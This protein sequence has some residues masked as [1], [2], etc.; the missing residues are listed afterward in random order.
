MPFDRF[1]IAPVNTGLQTNLRPWLIQDDA[2]QSLQNAYIFRGRVRKRFG[3]TL[4]DINPL[5]SR[6]RINIGTVAAHTIPGVATQLKI[7]QMFSV[8]NDIFTIFQLGAG[9]LTKSTNAGVT[10]TI[11]STTNPNTVVFTGEPGASIVYYYPAEPVMGLTQYETGAVNNHPSY[12]FDEQFAY[13]FTPGSGWNRSGTAVWHGNDLNFFWTTNWKGITQ[14]VVAM[15]VTNFHV[16]NLNG[17]GV[18]TDDPIWETQN[19]STWA[20]FTPYFLPNSG[21]MQTGPF[22]QTCRIIVAFKDRLVLLNTVENDN[23]GGTGVNSWYPQRARFSF[24]GSP[25]ARNAW[26]EPGQM[27]ASGGVVNNNNI[28]AG[29]GFVDA[30]TDEQIIS[31]EFIKDRLIVYFERSTW[32]L[33]YTG[34]EILPFVWQK[35]NTELGS[36]STFSTIPFDREV[37]TI[38]NT[39]VHSCNGSNVDRIDIKIPDE[40]FEFE[41]KNNG[42]LRTAGIR[43]YFSELSYWA[44]VSDLEEPTQKFPNQM[45]IYNY[46]NQSWALND[47]CFTAFGYFEQ[48]S[49]STWQ[50]LEDTTWEQANFTWNSGIEEANQRVVIAGTPDGFVLIIN[51]EI[52]R[53]AASMYIT[54]MTIPSAINGVEFVDLEVINHNFAVQD[55]V[56]VENTVGISLPILSIYPVVK[57]IDANNITIKAPDIS[58]TYLGG[59]TL[60][61]VSN[62]Q[63]L[64]KQYNPYVDK[65]RNVYLHKVDFAVL[66]TEDGQITVDYFPSD[67]NLSMIDQGEGTG[68]IMG[69]N[70][71]ETS[72][73]DPVLYPLEQVQD[74]LW[75]PV[76]FQTDGTCIQLYLYFTDAQMSIPSIVWANFD[77]EGF[78]LYTQPTTA[79]LQ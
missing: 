62:I 49:D 56:A 8:G 39:G 15:F 14:N 27:D 36:Q 69:N 13:L 2:F 72:P 3:S 25:F 22:V 30:S 76:Y 64:T 61:R 60:A 23:S 7:G 1:L 4:M 44:F 50:S 24:N 42:P 58:G 5:L 31:A 40:I 6:L 78:C 18:A 48:Q 32:E 43:D 59:G 38:G 53:N 75:H 65:D 19:G 9:V 79:R 10:A 47:D 70:T 68:A 57:I 11:N 45:L 52:S 73:Y 17:A 74:R 63:I 20:V 66:R 16:T 35:L 54:T 26:Y 46:R 37:L 77:L 67:T 51:P 29:G 33:V 41:A 55:Y 71:L 21:L 12:A 28:A 34:N